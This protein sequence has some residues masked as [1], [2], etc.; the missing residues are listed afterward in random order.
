MT[1]IPGT[2]PTPIV[3]SLGVATTVHRKPMQMSSG[4]QRAFPSPSMSKPVTGNPAYDAR[5][6]NIATR[7]RSWKAGI[8]PS[9]AVRNAVSVKALNVMHSLML[10]ALESDS[11]E[12]SDTMAET[13]K[14]CIK[15]GDYEMIITAESFAPVSYILS[16]REDDQPFAMSHGVDFTEVDT[17]GWDTEYWGVY[18]FDAVTGVVD[19]L[20]ENNLLAYDEVPSK[21]DPRF[22]AHLYMSSTRTIPYDNSMGQEDLIMLVDEF[23]E[24]TEEIRKLLDEGV[25]DSLELRAR[26][27]G[28]V[29]AHLADGAL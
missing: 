12:A 16:E 23:P 26:L 28:K 8:R 4:N 29:I 6:K 25:D 9:S 24:R 10:T 2:V 20:R 17:N 14:N 27:E 22:F 15:A 19:C 13:I 1:N 5:R 3:N 21:K 11:R 7:N 18:D